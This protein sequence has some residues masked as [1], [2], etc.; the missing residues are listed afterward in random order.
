[1]SPLTGARGKAAL[2]VCISLAAAG[3]AAGCDLQEDADLERGRTLFVEKC[4]TCHALTEART[5]AT[6]GPDLDL[7]F[8]HARSEG[9]DQ[10]TIEG[11]VSAQVENPRYIRE[12][13]PDYAKTFMPAEIVTGRDL[14]DVA[15]YVASVAGV[16]GIQPP[17]LGSAEEIFAGQC[18]QCHTLSA[19]NSAANVGPNLDEALPGQNEAEIE[20]SIRDPEEEISPLPFEGQSMP[21][22]DENA[23]PD[24]S[25]AELI[26]YLIANAGK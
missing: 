20:Q 7:S 24:E 16:P 22:F 14:E 11:V 23:I 17:D 4:G 21:P 13:D 3:A 12:E 10:D 8:A 19:A 2:I 6:I 5:A 15:T 9:M 1:M 25:L 26:K 18:A